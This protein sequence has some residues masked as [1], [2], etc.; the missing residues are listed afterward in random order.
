VRRLER[1]PERPA[2]GPFE[3]LEAVGRRRGGGWAITTRHRFTRSAVE[4]TWT[5]R[6][7]ARGHATVVA[8]L[9]SW[10]AGASAV[11][12]LADGRVAT[13]TVGGPPL[14]LEAIRELRIE[15]RAGAY[16]VQPGS[17]ARGTVRAVPTAPEPTNPDPGPTFELAFAE[18]DGFGRA[19]L[20][21][22]IVPE[23]SRA[24]G[25]SAE[26]PRRSVGRAQ[27]QDSGARPTGS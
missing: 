18:G 13:V 24:L 9:P 5:V 17:G 27:P 6:R 15:S 7:R 20:A 22:R 8:Q 3:V 12:M 21:V 26:R 4:E 11:A 14:R 10:G 1:L 25:A 2:A 19:R 16:R 23:A